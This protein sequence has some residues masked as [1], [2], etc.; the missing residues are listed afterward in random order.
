MCSSPSC[1]MLTNSGML[2]A[3]LAAVE[4]SMRMAGLSLPSSSM[5]V[6]NICVYGDR[7][8]EENTSQRPLG[9]K[10]CHEFIRDVLQSM[11]RAT[12]PA[13]GTIY[14]SLSG[15]INCPLRFLTKTIHLPSGE[16]LGK[17]LLIPLFDA[18]SIGTA[19]PPSPPL[20]GTL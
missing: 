14:N 10:L 1:G 7:L 3:R 11:R 17:L 5:W 13:T 8:L 6:R 19:F 9:E 15:R 16:T 2:T 12:P 20:N 18:P 4:F